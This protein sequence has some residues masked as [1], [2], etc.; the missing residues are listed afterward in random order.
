MDAPALLVLC[1]CPDRDS[2]LAL[3]QVAVEEALA[4]CVNL[5]PGV[6]SI[7]RWQGAVETAEEVL[8]MI[9]TRPECF[10][11]L[12]ARLRPLH[13][14]EVPEFIGIPITTGLPAYLAWIADSV[15]ERP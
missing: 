4:A 7:Y 9:K 5:L 1:T 3:A 8:L 2:A 6:K 14:Y 10:D 11:A 15:P 13:P 12:V